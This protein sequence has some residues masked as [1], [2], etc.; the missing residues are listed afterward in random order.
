MP[1][2]RTFDIH[3]HPLDRTKRIATIG[4]GV[5]KAKAI[6]FI[7][8]VNESA[9]NIPGNFKLY[10]NYPNPFNPSTIIKY[11]VLKESKI[12]IVVYDETGQMIETL[13]DGE[14]PAGTYTIHWN[15]SK[16]SKNISS[17]IYFLRLIA[18]NYSQTIKMIYLK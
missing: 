1:I 6:D 14:K 4:R 17:G 8:D 5:W 2:V 10:Q 11:D 3:Y 13:F 15:I 18:N 9:T 7:T 16:E 12:K